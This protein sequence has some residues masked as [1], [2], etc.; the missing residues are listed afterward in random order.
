[1]A[2]VYREKSSPGLEF[3]NTRFNAIYCSFSRDE[4]EKENTANKERN[5]NEREK[6]GKT[7][8]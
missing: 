2:T 3:T 4:L 6:D 7:K 8:T 5:R 1:M